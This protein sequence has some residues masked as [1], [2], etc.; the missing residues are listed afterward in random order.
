MNSIRFILQIQKVKSIMGVLVT[1]SVIHFIENSLTILVILL[2]FWNFLFRPWRRKDFVMFLVASLFFLIQNYAVLK[3]G[4]FS[5]KHK[6]ILLMPYYEPFMWGFYYLTIT[7]FIGEQPGTHRLEAKV[8]LGMLLTGAAFSLFAGNSK[9]LLIFTGISTSILIL[10]FHERHDLLY[11]L[12]ALVLGIVVEIFGV[13]TGLWSYPAP[14]F[15]GIPFWFATMW[16]SVGI[17]GR[18]LLVPLA[19]WMADKSV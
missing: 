13:L 11:A 7:R 12:C 19:E 14:D 18:R 10:M 3:T 16:V 6:D 5:F 9:N 15:L 4:G 2:P 17:L 8:F 1:L